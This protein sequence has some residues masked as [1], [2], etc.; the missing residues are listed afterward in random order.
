VDVRV[1]GRNLHVAEDVAEIAIEKVQHASRIFDDGGSADVEFSERHNPSA[2][3]ENFRVEITTRV[4]SHTVRVEAGGVDDRAAL[5]VAV[6]KF[7]RQLRRLKER[8]IQRS[9]KTVDKR[10]NPVSAIS[11]VQ[12]TG[13]YSRVVKTKRFAMRPMTSEEAA[14]Q[15]EML[16]HDFFFF[17]DAESGNHC[18]LYHRHDGTLGLIE[19]E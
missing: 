17:L 8:L 2:T 14:L 9:R 15:M 19:P 11:D 12:E 4:A 18:V 1:H 3:E 5:D 6:D 16:G 13:Q 10:L 7:E